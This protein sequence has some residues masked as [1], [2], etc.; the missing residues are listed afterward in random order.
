[1]YEGQFFDN[2]G[3]GRIVVPDRIVA[4]RHIITPNPGK[5]IFENFDTTPVMS[6]KGGGATA[7]TTGAQ[8]MCK[9]NYSNWEQVILGAGQTLIAPVMGA[10]GLNVSGDAADNEGFEFSTG[11][12]AGDKAHFTVGTDAAFFARLRFTIA[13]VSDTDDCAFGFRKAEAFQA[14]VDDY[15]EMAALNVIS[16][17]IKIETILNDGA[18]TTTDT[19]ENWA[20]AATHTLEVD[21]SAAGAVTYKIDGHAPSTTAAFTFDTGE[22]VV[23]FFY[24]LH[25]AASTAGIVVHEFECGL[26]ADRL[27]P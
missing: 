25:A 7:G 6:L 23:P 16:G 2:L 21:V 27:R 14:N 19:T 15:D 26:Q 9:L 13:D 18:T 3:Q 12:T 1:M 8:N 24:F 5:H 20:D 22:V 11:I 17:D 10:T 4:G